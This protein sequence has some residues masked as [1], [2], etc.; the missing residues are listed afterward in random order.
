MSRPSSSAVSASVSKA[1]AS[2]LC[3]CHNLEWKDLCHIL[4]RCSQV[5]GCKTFHVYIA[6]ATDKH[7][8][9]LANSEIIIDFMNY[10]PFALHF[11]DIYSAVRN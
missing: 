1:Y 10:S 3:E 4:G 2:F 8:D 5:R 11:D 7:M 6:H 9:K